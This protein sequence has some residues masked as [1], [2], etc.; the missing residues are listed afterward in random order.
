MS[1]QITG[2]DLV[3]EFRDILE[4]MTI[5]QIPGFDSSLKKIVSDFITAFRYRAIKNDKLR[6]FFSKIIGYF[7][8]TVPVDLFFDY[9]IF[10]TGK[11]ICPDPYKNYELIVYLIHTYSQHEREVL[12]KAYESF[13]RCHK[14]RDSDN[15]LKEWLF[16]DALFEASRHVEALYETWYLKMVVP[17]L[18]LSKRGRKKYFQMV[19]KQ[20]YGGDYSVFEVKDGKIVN[21]RTWVEEFKYRVIHL[22]ENLRQAAEQCEKS[23]RMAKYLSLLADAY[24]C[25]DY[26]QLRKLW[27]SVNEAWSKLPGDSQILPL[28]CFGNAKEHPCCVAPELHLAFCDDNQ[29][30]ATQVQIR[31]VTDSIWQ[32]AKVINKI[33][34]DLFLKIK[35]SITITTVKVLFRTGFWEDDYAIR[36]LPERRQGLRKFIIDTQGLKLSA[37]LQKKIFFGNF[38]DGFMTA[39]YYWSVAYFVIAREGSKLLG[40]DDRLDLRLGRKLELFEELRI[41][42]CAVLS[43]LESVKIFGTCFIA[44]IIIARI[45]WYFRQEFYQHPA[46]QHKIREC[47]ALAVTLINSGVINLD[48]G[49][50]VVY[51]DDCLKKWVIEIEKMFNEL[52]G[53]YSH[54]I[55]PSI[56]VEDLIKKYLKK[57]I[58]QPLVDLI[59]NN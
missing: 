48:N 6:S 35:N 17:Y 25:R 43:L 38:N 3:V 20:A 53:A 13:L 31:K 55:C 36:V 58:Y 52:M 16:L 42:V 14:F 34:D 49:I 33:S 23:S 15:I 30:F 1:S 41:S 4:E 22:S 40:R 2:G 50:T 12:I 46:Y 9:I 45:Q 56:L 24:V 37:D 28:H 27:L 57:E 32:K 8:L 26:R 11:I 21:R 59:S 44:G 5:P 47:K 19:S 7:D 51:S 54:R 18:E 10:R 39:A 29:E